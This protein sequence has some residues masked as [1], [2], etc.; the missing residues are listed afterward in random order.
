[1]NK[2]L[3]ALLVCTTTLA[4]AKPSGH[5]SRKS[6]KTSHKAHRPVQRISDDN[7]DL[8]S[9]NH[10]TG[11]R[12]GSMWALT[13][14]AAKGRQLPASFEAGVF[15]QQPL[16]RALSVQGEVVYY[17]ASTA[18]GR[19]SGLRLP[20]LLVINPFYNV[21][22][23]VG[24]QLQV[25]TGGVAEPMASLEADTNP[26]PAAAPA[27]RITGGLVV[28]GEARAGFLRVGVRYGLPFGD[29]YDL[30]AAG[31]QVGSAWQAGQV[32]AYLGV[33]F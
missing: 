1:M 4:S 22:V 3:L 28:G 31:Q 21:S 12:V 16:N 25:R 14:A 18:T 26:V 11:V 24:P 29:L 19:S 23:H 5:R 32:Q 9:R 30:K 6:H 8:P 17:R 27:P 20:A 10:G 33:G 2:L 13:Q 15:R 7:E